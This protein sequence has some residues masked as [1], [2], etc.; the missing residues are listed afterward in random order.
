MFN[1]LADLFKLIGD[2]ARCR[3]FSLL[4][5]MKCVCDLVNVLNMIK[6]SVSHQLTHLRKSVKKVYYNTYDNCIV[7]LLLKVEKSFCNI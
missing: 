7:K 4:I 3:I 5:K 6:S 2:T 1:H